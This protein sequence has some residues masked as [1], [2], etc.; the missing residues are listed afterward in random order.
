[1]S[2]R[3]DAHL[4]PLTTIGEDV[5]GGLRCVVVAQNTQTCICITITTIIAESDISYS[6]LY[7]AD[8]VHRE[9]SFFAINLG[10]KYEIQ[11]P[12]IGGGSKCIVAPTKL[13]VSMAPC[14][15][16]SPI[17][18][19]WIVG[20]IHCRLSALGSEKKQSFGNNSGKSQPI[21]TKFGR[22]AQ[23]K[24]TPTS[25]ANVGCGWPMGINGG[26]ARVPWLPPTARVFRSS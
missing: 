24:G 14:P 4:I 20:C 8:T 1:M 5:Y 21:R 22:H 17:A 10:L 2:R 11:V 16:P 19:P 23:I 13:L 9:Q 26:L 25:S 7:S 6:L 3:R 15:L 18:P 12:N